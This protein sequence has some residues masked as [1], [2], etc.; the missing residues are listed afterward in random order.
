MVAVVCAV[1]AG[2]S[3]MLRSGPSGCAAR[4]NLGVAGEWSRRS[5]SI[6]DARQ[7]LALYREIGSERVIR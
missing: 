2:D 5:Q 6:D 7:A 1:T 4:S 3:K